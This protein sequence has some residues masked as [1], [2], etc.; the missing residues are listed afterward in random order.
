MC[1]L[2]VG[3]STVVHAMRRYSA[4]A[5]ALQYASPNSASLSIC[6][7]ICPRLQLRTNSAT[8]RPPSSLQLRR[9]QPA[10]ALGQPNLSHSRRRRR[11]AQ[12]DGLL[13]IKFEYGATGPV[14]LLHD[15]ISGQVRPTRLGLDRGTVSRP[16]ELWE[17]RVDRG[18]TNTRYV[19]PQNHRQKTTDGRRREVT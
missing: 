6:G 15:T 11:G 7:Y 1:L 17:S 3:S 2:S 9:G 4:I 18:Q 19:R 13:P 12:S 10:Q 14:A 16:R 8:P 5:S